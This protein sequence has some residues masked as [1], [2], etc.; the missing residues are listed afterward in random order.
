MDSGFHLA[1]IVPIAG[2]TLDF[3]MPWHDSLLPIAPGYLAVEKAVVDCAEAGCETIWVVCHNDTMPLLKHRVGDYVED[4][5]YINRSFERFPS[6]VRRRIPIYYVA[7][8]PNDRDR[9][10]CLGWSVLYGAVVASDFVKGISR[11]LSP[12]KFFVSFPYGIVSASTLREHRRDISSEDNFSLSYQGSTVLDNEH[13][14]FSFNMEQCNY[15]MK[16]LRANGT[17]R[18]V[19]YEWGKNKRDLP[20]EEQY[21][22]RFFTLEQVFQGLQFSQVVETPYY[23]NIDNWEHYRDYM[24]HKPEEIERPSKEILNP[25]RHLKGVATGEFD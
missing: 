2:E 6:Q 14:P 1:G 25:N 12:N 10:D 15:L 19:D 23:F 13:L 9:R 4:P 11:W 17:G 24:A 18:F 3:D 16:Q 21:S 7:V 22:A 5:L 8:H 20:I